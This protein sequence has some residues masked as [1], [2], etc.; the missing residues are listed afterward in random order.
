MQ[1]SLKMMDACKGEGGGGTPE[2]TVGPS[3]LPRINSH[4]T[5]RDSAP[6]PARTSA[7]RPT[8]GQGAASRHQGEDGSLTAQTQVS[9]GRQS[10]QPCQGGEKMTRVSRAQRGLVL[11]EEQG[12]GAWVWVTPLAPEPLL[13]GVL[14]GLMCL[15]VS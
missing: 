8:T 5:L 14:G 10:H 4:L 2:T 7:H 11:R 3:C 6:S 1:S 15:H 12:A 13:S 9:G